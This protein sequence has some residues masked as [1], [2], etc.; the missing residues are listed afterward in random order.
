MSTL[1]SDILYAFN[2]IGFLK[3]DV[4]VV[5]ELNPDGRRTVRG[6]DGSEAQQQERGQRGPGHDGCDGRRERAAGGG[7]GA[8]AALLGSAELGADPSHRGPGRAGAG[9]GPRRV[10]A[11]SGAG[12]CGGPG[13]GLLEFVSSTFLTCYLS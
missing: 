6:G 12:V 7:C 3:K 9:A 2:L 4:T 10:D 11:A 1:I 13:A 5:L 8:G